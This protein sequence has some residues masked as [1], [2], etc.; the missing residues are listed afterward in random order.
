MPSAPQPGRG[1]SILI[2]I[3]CSAEIMR[4]RRNVLARGSS[5]AG[6]VLIAFLTCSA[7]AAEDEFP[8]TA[9]EQIVKAGVLDTAASPGPSS[10][11]TTP[12]CPPG[13]RLVRHNGNPKCAWESDLRGAPASDSRGT[14]TFNRDLWLCFIL[15]GIRIYDYYVYEVVFC[16][17]VTD[18][19][20]PCG[21]C[22][23]GK[24]CRSSNGQAECVHV[25]GADEVGGGQEPCQTCGDGEVANDGGTDC[26]ACE[27]GE[28]STG[29]TCNPDPCDGVYCPVNG[30]CDGGQCQCDAGYKP[31]HRIG[32][33]SHEP[34]LVLTCEDRCAGVQCGKN[35]YCFRGVCV[36]NIGFEDPD[37]DGD[38]SRDC[39]AGFHDPDDDGLCTRVCRYSDVDP[40][41]RA[42]LLTI[43]R[44][45]WE[46]G[47]TYSCS[48][49]AVVAG[50]RIDNRNAH[51]NGDDVCQLS[52]ASV[53][54]SIL[55]AGHSHPYFAWD[56]N[57]TVEENSVICSGQLLNSEAGM[58][59]ANR[60]SVNFSV[61]DEH[62]AETLGKPYYLVVPERNVV[63]VYR[64]PEHC[65]ACEWVVE[66]L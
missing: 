10:S 4:I 50:T 48:D 12:S 59:M 28:S 52:I 43:P 39:P 54:L 40:V 11:P 56:P 13:A 57:K 3:D 23:D 49:N 36:C 31:T 5:A 22:A 6:L 37:G 38:C 2:C 24:Q 55:A 34:E 53:P 51:E 63:K 1:Q 21:T 16:I 41:A 29:G 25:C 19:F 35:A 32:G 66:V 7:H 8:G 17:N 47:E 62:G 18:L 15:G 9:W 33:F 60:A 45:P 30:H 27:H 26:V 42:S 64:H 20:E 58:N 44:E 14:R 65:S 61:G 46:R